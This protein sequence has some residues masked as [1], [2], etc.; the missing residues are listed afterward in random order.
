[1]A[2][3]EQ[4]AERIRELIGKKKGMTE[5]KMFGGIGFMLN[6]NMCCG[7]S[8][9]DLIIRL[10]DDAM[11]ALDEPHV[12]QWKMMAGKPMAGM[13]LVAPDGVKGKKLD[14]WLN[15]AVTYAAALPPK[16]KKK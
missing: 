1:M 9:N 5:L 16:K 6:G 7:V 4:L 8:K 3:D 14:A 11:A 13:I 12:H 2:F 10:G 15:R